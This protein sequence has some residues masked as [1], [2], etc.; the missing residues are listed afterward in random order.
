MR[1]FARKASWYNDCWGHA[2]VIPKTLAA[3]LIGSSL[4]ISGSLSRSAFA[5]TATEPASPAAHAKSVTHAV[6]AE[7]Y[8]RPARQW[9]G[10]PILVTDLAAAGALFVATQVG[11]QE[12]PWLVLT[13]LGSYVLGSPIVHVAEGRM[14]A[15][16]GSLALRV[17]APLLGGGLGGIIGGVASGAGEC[18]GSEW[19]GFEYVIWGAMI[20]FSS[21]VVGALVVDHAELAYKPAQS[22]R[23][24]LSVVPTYKPI[25]GEAGVAVSGRW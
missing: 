2:V 18:D 10:A 16:L 3:T 21:G 5:Q 4:L 17:G 11:D 22:P 1:N 14:A 20:G 19:C 8:S 12:T 9:Y 24:A 7:R 25:T 23:L 6:P 13:G 15:G